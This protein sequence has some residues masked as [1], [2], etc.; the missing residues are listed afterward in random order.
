MEKGCQAVE[1]E[2]TSLLPWTSLWA[3]KLY[4]EDLDS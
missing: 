1:L 2:R 4:W 3:G